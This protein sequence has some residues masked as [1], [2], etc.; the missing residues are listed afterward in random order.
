MAKRTKRVTARKA[1]TGSK[2]P[3]KSKAAKNKKVASRPVR[4]KPKQQKAKTG[5]KRSGVKKSASKRP[6]NTASPN[7]LQTETTIV[8]VVEEPVPGVLVVTE[9]VETHTRTPD[10]TTRLDVDR[11]GGL[12]SE[13]K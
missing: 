12:E 9:F 3:K 13:E 11:T 1:K 7:P 4:A 2:A 10:T 8:D 6:R 5:R